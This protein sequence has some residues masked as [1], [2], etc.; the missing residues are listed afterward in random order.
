MATKVKVILFFGCNPM[1]KRKTIVMEKLKVDWE[2]TEFTTER[3]PR[4]LLN[5][6]GRVEPAA[7][8]DG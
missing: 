8:E 7:D 3:C 6:K 5:E 2:Q 4:M 1:G